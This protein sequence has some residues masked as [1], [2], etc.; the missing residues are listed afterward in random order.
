MKPKLS[1]A[2]V[3]SLL[4][5]FFVVASAVP[6]PVVSAQTQLVTAQP[7]Y[8]NL[9][10]T[11][12]IAV[13]GP[14]A[15]TYTVIVA[16]PNG[17]GVQKNFLFSSAGLTLNATF[18]NATAGFERIVD[19][20]GTYNVFVESEGQVVASTSFYATNKLDINM[21]VVQAGT[22]I[23]VQTT[24]RGVRFV[25]FFNVTYASN[26]AQMGDAS[27]NASVTFTNPDHTVGVATYQ[28]GTYTNGTKWVGTVDPNWNFT[29]VGPWSPSVNASDGLG[30]SGTFKYEGEPF[31]F[32][33]ATLTTYVS[34]LGKSGQAV[35]ALSD[36]ESVSI[37]AQVTYP[38]WAPEPI[39][40]FAGPLDQARG[41][42][43]TALVG[44]G[45][46]NS[47]TGT[48]GGGSGQGGLIAKVGLT[49]SG[50][51]GIWTGTFNATSLPTLPAGASYQVVVNAVD[52][53]NPPNTGTATIPVAPASSSAAVTVTSTETLAQ[54]QAS[55]VPSW[56]YAAMA[57][58]L[59]AG[60]GVGY[61][62]KRSSSKS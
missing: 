22:C 44:Y 15:G 23:Y 59:L 19:Q 9:G 61:V 18:G 52:D 8:I 3:L 39:S 35:T 13:T 24:D 46:Y 2:A 36:G 33:P 30:N 16:A 55:S 29:S 34:L 48:F 10:M 11:T 28:N 56:A 26:G 17:I 4:A 6:V 20:V 47:T 45:L 60:V 49:Y 7:G 57:L 40:G 58:L 25:T 62:A 53:A 31:L 41:G 5:F 43:V 38:P 12:S 50:N 51:G 32:L 54:A 27:P 37:E 42:Q 21:Q 1:T 14:S